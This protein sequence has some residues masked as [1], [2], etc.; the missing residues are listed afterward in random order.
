MEEEDRW[1]DGPV[2]GLFDRLE[3]IGEEHEELYDSVVREE[4]ADL[5]CRFCVRPLGREAVTVEGMFTPA[6]NSALAEVMSRFFEDVEQALDE[7]FDGVVSPRRLLDLLQQ[8]ERCSASSQYFDDFFGY[9]TPDAFS[10]ERVD[11]R[12]RRGLS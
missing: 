12:A 4:L 2:L 3:A 8:E 7:R 10:S 5:I 9:I 6:A 11:R 1:L